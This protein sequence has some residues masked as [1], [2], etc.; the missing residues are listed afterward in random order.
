LNTGHGDIWECPTC[1]YLDISKSDNATHWDFG[2]CEHCENIDPADM[3]CVTCV[4]NE[5]KMGTCQALKKALNIY[6]EEPTLVTKKEF[7]IW[8]N[9]F[10]YLEEKCLEVDTW[11]RLKW[12]EYYEN[13]PKNLKDVP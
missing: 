5:G 2:V 9:Y 1:I 8:A 4:I 3:T 13:P 12:L 7:V 10:H 11:N 6:K